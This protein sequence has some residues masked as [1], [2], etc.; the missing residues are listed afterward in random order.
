VTHGKI[1]IDQ[2]VL[3]LE[4]GELT[5]FSELA[6]WVPLGPFFNLLQFVPQNLEISKCKS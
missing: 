5:L 3:G 1:S 4:L 6:I 2:E